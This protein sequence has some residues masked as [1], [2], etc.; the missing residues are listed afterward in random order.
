M[1]LAKV[2]I[3]LRQNAPVQKTRPAGTNF[4]WGKMQV[5]EKYDV[6]MFKSV[7]LLKQ[8]ARKNRDTKTTCLACANNNYY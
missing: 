8:N 5:L 3:L 6:E 4:C 7:V 2:V 1:K